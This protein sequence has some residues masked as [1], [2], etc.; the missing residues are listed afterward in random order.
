MPWHW[1]RLATL[2]IL[3]LLYT[4]PLSSGDKGLWLSVTSMPVQVLAAAPDRMPA[5]HSI[6][7]PNGGG[8]GLAMACVELGEPA[9]ALA[10]LASDDPTSSDT[11]RGVGQAASS[12]KLREICPSLSAP[13][14]P[15]A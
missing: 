2:V 5:E 9:P 8:P 15:P 6:L 14:G 10:P 7:L 13:R 4:S 1:S 11:W 12:T 3:G